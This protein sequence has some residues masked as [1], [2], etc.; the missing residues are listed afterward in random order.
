[1]LPWTWTAS[2]ALAEIANV[3]EGELA[4]VK[5][6]RSMRRVSRA[7]LR[8]DYRSGGRGP[9]WMKDAWNRA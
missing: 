7:V 2:A 6:T 3:I 9:Y 1:M 4:V 5:Q 8:R